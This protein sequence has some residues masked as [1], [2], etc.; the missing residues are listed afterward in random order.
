MERIKIIS[1]VFLFLLFLPIVSATTVTLQEPD[2]ETLDDTDVDETASTTNFGTLEQVTLSRD[3][4]VDTYHPYFKFNINGSVISSGNE[5]SESILSLW[6]SDAPAQKTRNISVWE[7]SNQTWS[8]LEITYDARPANG[9]YITYN[10]S[11]TS[12]GVRIE[13]NVTSWVQNQYNAGNDNVSFLLTYSNGSD[14]GSLEYTN[15]YTK[16]YD[17]VTSRRPYLEITYES[18]QIP[19]ITIVSPAN[20]TIGTASINFNL[21]VDAGAEA[22]NLSLD[23]SSNV[24]MTEHAAGSFGYNNASMTDGSHNVIYHCNNSIGT[25]VSATRWF[26]IDTDTPQITI[27]QPWNTTYNNNTVSFN[28]TGNEVLDW[29]AV[30]IGSHN[31]TLTN[32]SGEWNY[33]NSTLGDGVYNVQFWFND[34]TGNMN[35][36]NLTFT[37]SKTPPSI[38]ILQPWNTTYANRTINFNI[39]GNETLSWAAVEINS[40]NHSLT[41]RSGEWNY[42]NNTLEDGVYDVSF[43]FNDTDGNMNGTSIIFTISTPVPSITISQPWNTTYANNTISF[44]ITG[45]ETLSWAAVQIS[46]TNH[47]LTNQSGEWN[48]FNNTLDDGVYAVTFWFNNTLGNMNFT[49]LTFTIDTPAPNYTAINPE[50][51]TITYAGASQTHMFNANWTAVFHSIDKVLLSLDGINYTVNVYTGNQYR[52][53][54]LGLTPG[55]HYFVW[56]ANDTQNNLNCTANF[57]Y[58]L[59]TEAENPG[60][61]GGGGG[62]T[63]IIEGDVCNFTLLPRIGLSG[64]AK[65]G[66]KIAPMTLRVYNKNV[67]QSFYLE[68]PPEIAEYCSVD[69]HMEV[70]IPPFGYDEFVINCIAPNETITGNLIIASSL[71][72]GEGRSITIGPGGVWSDISNAFKM[73]SE[74]DLFGFLASSV[75]GVP[76]MIWILIIVIIIIVAILVF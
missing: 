71:Q 13:F 33:L 66:E 24:S 63:T 58:T 48:Y 34:S 4:P 53:T 69:F 10:M 59:R 42:L 1:F 61:P 75:L 6:V 41:N 7:V 38:T 29:A 17:V 51:A 20:T 57:T 22:C 21:T 27:S 14:M 3:P 37:I 72:C 62:G 55:D 16:D 50:S 67:T 64:S 31:H 44:N 12:V 32:Q 23:G 9:T 40:T 68:L 11:G 35:S 70:D 47:T 76:M 74:G 60:G 65:P 8:E 5:V 39:T 28:M 43:W 56:C 45:N 52:K 73:L 54:F 15:F 46:S 25:N 36:T 26:T 18:S 19:T 49:S 30:Q 2:N